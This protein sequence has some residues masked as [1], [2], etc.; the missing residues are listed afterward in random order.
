VSAPDPAPPGPSRSPKPLPSAAAF[1]G[2]GATVAGCVGLGVLLGIWLDAR[3]HTSPLFLML[4]LLLGVAS[5]VWTVVVQ[6]RRF[7]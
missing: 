2:L 7:L 1:L 5:A 3:A 6:V 4:G